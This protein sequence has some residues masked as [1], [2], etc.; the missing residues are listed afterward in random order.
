MA[1]ISWLVPRKTRQVF[2]AGEA[3]SALIDAVAQKIIVYE[4]GY[5]K[6]LV[7]HPNNTIKD[8]LL[9]FIASIKDPQAETKNS[10]SIGAKTIELIEASKRS[11]KDS[12]SVK[13]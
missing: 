8:E 10:G 7:I 2:I 3:R 12:K 6:D 11:M 1:N 5:T 9:H 13:V 4:S